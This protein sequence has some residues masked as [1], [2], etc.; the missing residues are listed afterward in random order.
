MLEGLFQNICLSGQ[1]HD[2]ITGLYYNRHRFYDPRLGAYISQDPIG[3]KGGI[4]LSSYVRNP[5]QWMD[6]WGLE[7]CLVIA[8][9]GNTGIGL[10]AALYGNNS[11]R[12]KWLYDP[13]GSYDTTLT[14]PSGT[15]YLLT[16]DDILDE[17]NWDILSYIKYHT[18]QGDSVHFSCTKTTKEQEDKLIFLAEDVGGSPMLCAASVSEV[19]KRSG[20]FLGFKPSYFPGNLHFPSL[21]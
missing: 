3:L 8:R 19:L 15:S 2:R 6:P 7:T 1:F 11:S 16:K 9:G 20:L 21:K 13:G 14:H 5:V 12:G 17:N 18:N 10:H 4:N